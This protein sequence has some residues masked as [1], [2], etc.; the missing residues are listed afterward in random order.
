VFSGHT[1]LY[2]LQQRRGRD[3]ITTATTGGISFERPGAMDHLT[4]VTMT[5]D[6]PKIVNL[7]MNGIIDKEDISD[8]RPL[9][10]TALYPSAADPTSMSRK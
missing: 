6:G 3:F 10:N 1:H 2:N 9:V 5:H 7:L 8:D 4:W